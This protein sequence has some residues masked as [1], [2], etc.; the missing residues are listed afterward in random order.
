ML[1]IFPTPARNAR[2]FSKV[3]LK[4]SAANQPMT[5]EAKIALISA[6][7][8]RSR[9]IS[10]PSSQAQNTPPWATSPSCAMPEAF[11]AGA[12]LDRIDNERASWWVL[13]FR[14]AQ[15]SD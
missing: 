12:F 10:I 8:T 5:P 2:V 7:A 14:A 9:R 11:D 3:G 6:Q 13:K 4:V 15:F 1:V